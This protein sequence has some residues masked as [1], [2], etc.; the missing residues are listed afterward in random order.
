MRPPS[1]VDLL[2]NVAA[3]GGLSVTWTRRSRLGW[4]WPAGSELPL[5]ES[6]ERYRITVQGSPGT[7]TFEALAPQIEIPPDALTGMTGIA[8]ISVVQVGD[9][10]ESRPAAVSVTLG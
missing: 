5:G 2:A 9:F 6:S 3:D 10:A 7:M 8:T 4:M 1:P